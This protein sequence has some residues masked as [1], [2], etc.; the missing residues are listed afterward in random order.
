MNG[1][2]AHRPEPRARPGDQGSAAV[3]VTLVAPI[4]V[5][6]L[7]LVVAADRIT[8]ARLTVQEAAHQAA[9]TLTLNG[10]A[11][12]ARQQAQTAASAVTTGKNLPCT[13]LALT[14]DPPAAPPATDPGPATVAVVTVHLECTVALG[15]LTGIALPSSTVVT[16]SATSPLD[17][18]RSIP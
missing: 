16:A 2:G 7:L 6:L 1:F 15:D 9:R 17:R 14:V 5:A 4:M 12:V 11:A 10:D 18:Y 13:H 8:S 3:E